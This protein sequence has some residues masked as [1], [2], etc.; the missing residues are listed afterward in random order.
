MGRLKYLGEPKFRNGLVMG[1]VQVS[2]FSLQVKNQRIPSIPSIPSIQYLFFKHGI[3][4]FAPKT[5]WY[6]KIGSDPV[7]P[8][9]PI[10]VSYKLDRRDRRDRRPKTPKVFFLRSRRSRRL[11]LVRVLCKEMKPWV[12]QPYFLFFPPR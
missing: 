8:V 9:D 11:V 12:A 4:G 3:D 10:F 1:G 5:L 6:L 7:D 2:H